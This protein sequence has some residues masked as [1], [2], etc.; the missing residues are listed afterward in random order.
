MTKS[1]HGPATWKESGQWDRRYH[2]LAISL[3]KELEAVS[4]PRGRNWTMKEKIRHLP[5]RGM[6]SRRAVLKRIPLYLVPG[7]PIAVLHV[8]VSLHKEVDVPEHAKQRPEDKW[9]GFRTCVWSM[10]PARQCP[11]VSI[12]ETLWAD[13]R[14]V[15]VCE[16]EGF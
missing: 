10:R 12:K 6:V 9:N 1:S 11:K 2:A 5:M 14:G 3:L 15:F 8:E 13:W 4:K 16:G 7:T